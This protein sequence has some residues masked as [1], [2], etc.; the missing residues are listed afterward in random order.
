MASRKLRICVYAISKNEEQFVEKFC[1]SAQEADLILIADTGSTDGTVGVAKKQ[2][3]TVVHDICITPWRFDKARDAALALIPRD[4]DVCIS[5]DLD[6][7]LEPG[8]REEIEKVWQDDTTRLRYK[9]DW[10][11]GISFFYEKIHHRHGYHWHH[12]CHEYPRPDSRI[13]EVYAHTQKLLVSHHPDPKK[14]RGQYLDLLKL[15]VTED[16]A[17]PR[18]AFYYARELTFYRK[19]GEAAVA[20]FKYLDNPKADWPNERCYAMRLLG[21]SYDMLQQ[22]EEALVWYRKATE[23]APHTREPW[24]DLALALYN[25]KQWAECLKAA[26]AGLAITKREEVYTCDP[27]V[28]EEPLYDLASIAAWNLGFKEK[29]LDY[30]RIAAKIVPNDGR[31][32]ANLAMMEQPLTKTEP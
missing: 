25:R 30:C 17:C 23:T 13:K 29:A 11:C 15:A 21:K 32:A 4:Y 20:L 27:R 18:N 19:W 16:P 3:K 2:Q 22:P 5:L 24:H 28:W 14:S 9:F 10:G 6:E 31:I 7:I 8:W 12:P 1:K 26:E